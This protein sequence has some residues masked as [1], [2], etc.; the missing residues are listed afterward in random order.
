MIP[1]EARVEGW[2]ESCAGPRGE[3][4]REARRGMDAACTS[5][6]FRP[7]SCMRTQLTS[8]L[9]TAVV[10]RVTRYFRAACG[11]SGITA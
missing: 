2:T 11:R 5:A 8:E 1:C 9:A 10:E 6:A 7:R 3:L 4:I